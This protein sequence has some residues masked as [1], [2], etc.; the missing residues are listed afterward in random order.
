MNEPQT[1]EPTSTAKGNVM[2][3]VP[4]D[5]TTRAIT[6]M[7]MLDRALSQGATPDVLAK[8]M[9]LH[10]RWEQNQARRAF[11]AAMAA[12][13]AEI[14]VIGKNRKVDFTGKSG[15]RTNYNF[16]DLAEITRVVVPILA[17]HGLFHRFRTDT[18]LNGPVTVTCIVW[19]RDGHSE[20]NTLSAGRD[21]T[22]N[23]NDI[24]AIG[25]T[26]TFLS[27]YT[28]NAALGLATGEDDD[29]RSSSTDT[30]EVI[31]KAQAD[32]IKAK[33]AELGIDPASFLSYM[34]AETI[35][36]IPASQLKRAMHAIGASKAAKAQTQPKPKPAE[37]MSDFP[38]IPANLR[39]GQR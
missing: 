30:G 22:G 2:T 11:N 10:E 37:D 16:A 26:V 35:D 36:D 9:D 3:L 27:R 34:R 18:P 19:H 23:K 7:D 5:A 32:H 4:A 21:N 31:T 39:R 1:I 20:E 13:K 25:S 33:V 24:Q 38:D 28:L 8:F 14:P 15:V 17:K 29:G 12:A 6:P